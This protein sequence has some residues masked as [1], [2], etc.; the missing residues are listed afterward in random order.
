MDRSSDSLLLPYCIFISSAQDLPRCGVRGCD[1]LQLEEAGL[2]VAYSQID[3]QSVGG[4]R[5]QQSALEFHRVVHAIFAREAVVPFRFPNS[6]DECELREH[7]RAH[8]GK[9]LKFLRAH[10]ND[11]QMEVRITFA[12]GD[13]STQAASGSE[14]M[15]QRL[16]RSTQLRAAADAI[17]QH[18]AGEI[19]W[20]ER[21]TSGGVRL[22]ALIARESVFAFRERLAHFDSA[23][24]IQ[25]RASGPW[26]ATEFLEASC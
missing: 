10:A 14:H 16:A 21:E 13:S 26:P 7:L 25:V 17:R 23:K 19:E 22:F 2:N 9:Y 12:A 1:V 6:V 8:S 18:T 11:V 15:R 3:S 4:E 5:L 20:L 24:E